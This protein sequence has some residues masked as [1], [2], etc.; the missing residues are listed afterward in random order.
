MVHL[1]V[2]LINSAVQVT[3]CLHLFLVSMKSS[4]LHGHLT[5]HQWKAGSN[6]L[7]PYYWQ[8]ESSPEWRSTNANSL[9]A[10]QSL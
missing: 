1:N 2:Q 9:Q 6:S 7:S 10:E 3:T 5:F 4:T 8:D